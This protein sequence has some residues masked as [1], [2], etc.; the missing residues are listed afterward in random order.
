MSRIEE[1]DLYTLEGECRYTTIEEIKEDFDY[2]EDEFDEEVWYKILWKIFQEQ[3]PAWMK[4]LAYH[5]KY[6]RNNFGE[7]MYFCI[8]WAK[9]QEDMMNIYNEYQACL[10]NIE[11]QKDELESEIESAES[12]RDKAEEEYNDLAERIINATGDN[13]APD[14]QQVSRYTYVSKAW[15][16]DLSEVEDDEDFDKSEINAWLD[17]ME[18]WKDDWH[19]QDEIVHD[20]S[21]LVEQAKENYEK[22]EQIQSEL[23]YWMYEG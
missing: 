13:S 5:M 22:V 3:N 7:M 4:K 17:D 2:D 21:Q 18:G 12:E 1:K 16:V 19:D 14:V 23:E 15:D 10:D 20:Y 8:Y 9:Y 6:N 11:N